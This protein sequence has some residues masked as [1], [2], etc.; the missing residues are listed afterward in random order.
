MN[1]NLTGNVN[2]YVNSTYVNLPFQEDT[3]NNI[4]E[5]KFAITEVEKRSQGEIIGLT[6][7]PEEY[8]GMTYGMVA[9]WPEDFRVDNPIIQISSN[10]K[11]EN[12]VYNIE[13]NK[14]NPENATEMEMFALCSYADKIGKGSG[15]TFGSY[16]TMSLLR[17]YGNMV[18]ESSIENKSTWDDFQNAKKNWVNLCSEMVDFLGSTKN[19]DCY[20]LMMK[21]QKLL[22]FFN[23][24]KSEK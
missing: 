1:I 4:S 24:S 18:N 13:I 5:C 11:G 10:A 20:D 21:G 15:S 16:Q 22:D 3:T 12:H 19:I 6:M 9:I 23:S 2:P 17:N 7:I 8:N 14:I